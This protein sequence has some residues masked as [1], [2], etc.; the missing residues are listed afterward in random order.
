[1]YITKAVNV[2][3]STSPYGRASINIPFPVKHINVKNIIYKAAVPAE[4]YQLLFSSL[5]PDQPLG[6]VYQSDDLPI[7]TFS[8]ISI[9]FNTPTTIS[10]DYSF[11]LRNL[12]NSIGSATGDDV[13][14]IIMEFCS[15]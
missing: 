6:F 1:M 8:Q 14:S 12:D 13:C 4:A 5:S 11:E 9:Y 10:N 7:N 15:E 3:F 2:L